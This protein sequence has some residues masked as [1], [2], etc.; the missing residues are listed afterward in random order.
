MLANGNLTE[1]Q[2]NALLDA[3]MAAEKNGKD[4]ST[5]EILKNMRETGQFS[6]DQ[7]KT[8]REVN[9]AYGLAQKTGRE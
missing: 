9:F 2:Q 3:G 1:D 7:I 4:G 5:D 8:A 6:Q